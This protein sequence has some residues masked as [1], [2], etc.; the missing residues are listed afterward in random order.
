VIF[1]A[2]PFRPVVSKAA[3]RTTPTA[4]IG[5]RTSGLFVLGSLPSVV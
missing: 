5:P 3:T 4:G 2:W 1:A